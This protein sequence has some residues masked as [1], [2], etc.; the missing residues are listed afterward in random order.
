MPRYRKLEDE[1]G[2]AKCGGRS[3]DAD[4]KTEALVVAVQLNGGSECTKEGKRLRGASIAGEAGARGH[5]ADLARCGCADM[6]AL[7]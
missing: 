2:G 7:Q 1:R 5:V 6:D 4:D 3:L